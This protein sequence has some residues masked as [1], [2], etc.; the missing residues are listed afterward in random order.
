MERPRGPIDDP[1]WPADVTP[2]L[3]DGSDRAIH[4]WNNCYNDAFAE[5]YHGVISTPEVCRAVISRPEADP[6]GLLL[7]YRGGECVGFCRND[8]HVGRGE[9]SIL[10]VKKSAR[11]IGLG[12]ALLRWGVRWLERKDVPRVTLGVDGEN[13]NALHL[14]RSE[15]FETVRTREVWSLRV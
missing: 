3:F 5:H 4:D 8:R 1:Q 9:I 7:A 6:T 11:G 14:Y 10:G 12:R 13:E 2:R 15:G